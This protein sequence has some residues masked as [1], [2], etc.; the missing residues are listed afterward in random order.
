MSGFHDV[1]LPLAFSLGTTGGPTWRTEIVQLASGREFRNSQWSMSRRRWD[2]GGAVKS[3]ED[4]AELTAFFEARRGRLYGFRL[5]D[6]SDYVSAQSGMSVQ[7]TDQLLGLGDGALTEFQLVKRSI[8]GGVEQVRKITRPV[9]ASVRVGVN[10]VEQLSGWSVDG[11]TGLLNFINP[12]PQHAQIT[13]G[14]EFDIPVR[15]DADQLEVSMDVMGVGRIVS[16]PV[17]ELLE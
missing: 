9:A 4:L 12:P 7:A 3:A 2:I 6:V 13:A 15:F 17:I 11:T 16:A 14:F 5:R 8:S 1:R 10:D